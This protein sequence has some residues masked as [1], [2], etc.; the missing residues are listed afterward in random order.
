M[1]KL[2]AGAVDRRRPYRAEQLETAMGGSPRCCHYLDSTA[3][4]PLD[5]ISGAV[6]SFPHSAVPH[7][8]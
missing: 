2:H 5:A 8:R 4:Q 1:D 7:M 3:M 6:R